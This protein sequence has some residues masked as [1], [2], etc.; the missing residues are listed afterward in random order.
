MAFS[1]WPSINA[2]VICFSEAESASENRWNGLSVLAPF[3]AVRFDKKSSPS[4]PSAK[5]VDNR[6]F[7]TLTSPFVSAAVLSVFSSSESRPETPFVVSSASENPRYSVTRFLGL[8]AIRVSMTFQSA[9]SSSVFACAMCDSQMLP[10][11]PAT[12][13]FSK[14]SVAEP[15]P[16]STEK[17]EI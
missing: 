9:F 3:V 17:L 7:F 5:M 1:N 4:P 2:L 11:S 6:L 12:R 14:D 15:R 10:I 13:A 16:E 8:S